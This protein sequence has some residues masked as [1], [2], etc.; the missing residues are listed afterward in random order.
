[1]NL[2]MDEEQVVFTIE[3]RHNS[4]ELEPMHLRVMMLLGPGISYQRGQYW[5][6]YRFDQT[7]L[8]NMGG[9]MGL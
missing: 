7:L 5:I 9:W 4:V 8:Q 2:E 6:Q 3:R 1:M